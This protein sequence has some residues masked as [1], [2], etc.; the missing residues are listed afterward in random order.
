MDLRTWRFN[1]GLKYFFQNG[2]YVSSDIYYVKQYGNLFDRLFQVEFKADDEFWLTDLEFGYRV[3]KGKLPLGLHGLFKLNVN[4]IFDSD[5]DYQDTV[6]FNPRFS[7]ERT[8]FFQ[9]ELNF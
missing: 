5:F 9:A 8:I 2:F 4:N 1:T 7:Y 6:P 3:E